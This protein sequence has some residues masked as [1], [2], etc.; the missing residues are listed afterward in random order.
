M[1][2]RPS[3]ERMR[4]RA[5]M[6]FGQRLGDG[7]AE[8]GALMALGELAFHLLERPA[9]LGERVLGDADAGVGDGE[10]DA[11]AGGA[12]AHGDAAALAA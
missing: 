6:Q 4:M 10:H 5:A 1:V 2:P 7:E 3:V 8:A 12:S 11:V 9:E